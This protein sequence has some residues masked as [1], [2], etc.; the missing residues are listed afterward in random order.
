VAAPTG[1]AFGATELLVGGTTPA[2]EDG[3]GLAVGEAFAATAGVAPGVGEPIA[4]IGTTPSFT[5]SLRLLVELLL[6]A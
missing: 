3:P 1:L 6:C 5:L 4:A 2:V